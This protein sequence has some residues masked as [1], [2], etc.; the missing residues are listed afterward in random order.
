MGLQLPKWLIKL[1]GNLYLHKYLC[2]CVYKP[3]HYA[4]TGPEVRNVL[5][6][7]QPGDILLRRFDGYLNTRLMQGFWG[8]AALCVNAREVVHAVGVGVVREDIITFCRTDSVAVLRVRDVTQYMKDRA[9]AC[10][11][12]HERA[13]TAYDYQFRDRNHAVYCTEL[14]NICYQGLFN[15]DFE[16]I[17]GNC[18]LTP[19]GIRRSASITAEVEC[20]HDPRGISAR[21]PAIRPCAGTA[22]ACGDVLAERVRELGALPAH[23]KRPRTKT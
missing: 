20:T 1:I 8:H 2:W 9:I 6:T 14:V 11:E 15:D 13:R 10:A 3:H 7:A 22:A 16:M 21:L 18:I 19:D 12:E 17:A 4:V 5:K 23:M